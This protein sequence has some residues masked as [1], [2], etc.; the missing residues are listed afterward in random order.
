MSNQIY[1]WKRF[2]CSRTGSFNLSDGGYLADPDSEWRHLYNPDVISFE[3][4]TTIPCLVLLGEPGIGKTHAMQ[5]AQNAIHCKIKEEG[6][7]I[8]CLDLR[9]CGT[10]MML[11]RN[12]FEVLSTILCKF[13]F[14]DLFKE[15]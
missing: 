9:S 15:G 10:D 6:D 1:N 13:F 11:V 12:L 8:F 14:S 5:A 3:S 7:Q 4:I 2:W